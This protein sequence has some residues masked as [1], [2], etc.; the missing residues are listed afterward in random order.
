MDIGTI[1]ISPG[2]KHFILLKDTLFIS[3]LNYIFILAR[4][5]TIFKYISNFN[6]E[7]IIFI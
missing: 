5:L 2:N 7:H 1:I 3:N 4:K 6:K